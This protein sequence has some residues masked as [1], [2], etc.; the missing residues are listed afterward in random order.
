MS[1]EQQLR[2]TFER[3]AEKTPA[4]VDAHATVLRRHRRSQRRRLVGGIAVAAVLALAIPV[5]LQGLDRSPAGI[6]IAEPGP[7]FVPSRPRG[8]LSTDAKFL[9]DLVAKSWPRA[10]ED[11]PAAVTDQHVLFAG[12]VS[13]GRWARL[14]ARVDGVWMGLWLAGPTGADAAVLTPMGE[15]DP[16]QPGWQAFVGYIHPRGVLVVLASE[17]DVVEV[18]ERT[19]VGAD[20][21]ARRTYRQVET[22]DGVAVVE[23]DARTSSSVDLRVSRDGD[24]AIGGTT[25]GSRTGGV[26]SWFDRDI[27][28][29]LIDSRGTPNRLQVKSALESLTAPLALAPSEVSFTAVWGGSADVQGEIDADAAVV[30]VQL[31]S[32]AHALVGNW[33]ARTGSSEFSSMSGTSLLHLYPAGTVLPTLIAM[34]CDIQIDPQSAETRGRLVVVAPLSATSI[35]VLAGEDLLDVV[36]LTDGITTIAF[37]GGADRVVALDADGVVL[38]DEPIGGVTDIRLIDDGSIR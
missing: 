20:G 18:S 17:G 22:A 25:G 5:T 29:A 28:T 15:A 30:D 12:D 35:R 14:V 33:G 26:E 31:P 9:A 16:V 4:P 19:E 3:Y 34:R 38:A 24:P 21:V 13:A 8:S 27:S 7:E 10:P 36:P 1:V 11:G 37:P 23:L 2:D 6:E 32:G